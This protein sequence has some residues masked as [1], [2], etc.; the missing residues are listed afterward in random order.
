[1]PEDFFGFL[2]DLFVVG[3]MFVLRIGVPLLITLMLGAWLKHFLEEREAKELPESRPLTL[4]AQQ[5]CWDI[6]QSAE[7]EQ[8]RSAAAQRP[9]LPCW[10]ALQ[11]GGTGL[12]EMCYTCPAFTAHAPATVK[13]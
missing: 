8:A 3:Y 13:A 2:R 11:V 4:A 1:M 12:K 9:D 10:L 6:K 5:H 7:T